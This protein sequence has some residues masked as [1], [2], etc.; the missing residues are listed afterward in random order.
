M[1]DNSWEL[2]FFEFLEDIQLGRPPAA[3]LD[4][5]RAALAVVEKIYAASGQ[6]LPSPS[7]KAG[8]KGRG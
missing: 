6:V 1:G 7:P 5:A 3:N 4:D 2:E 8:E